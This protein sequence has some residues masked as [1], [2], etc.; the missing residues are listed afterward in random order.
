MSFYICLEIRT[1]AVDVQDMKK[2]EEKQSM[3]CNLH[4]MHHTKRT[5]ENDACSANKLRES[6]K[7][8]YRLQCAWF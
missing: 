1:P 2:M 6:E 8:Y 4:Q 5:G 3:D 7:D